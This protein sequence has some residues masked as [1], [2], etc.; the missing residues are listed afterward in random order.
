MWFGLFFSDNFETQ[1]G[2]NYHAAGL[3]PESTRSKARVCGRWF[4]GIDVESHQGHGCL[5]VVNVVFC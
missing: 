1:T 4:A 3:I 2:A 5:S